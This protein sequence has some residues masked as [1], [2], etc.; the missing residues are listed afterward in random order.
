[1]MEQTNNIISGLYFIRNPFNCKGTEYWSRQCFESYCRPPNP[2][3]VKDLT[4]ASLDDN[5]ILE[6]LRWATLGYHHN[7]DTKVYT[8]LNFLI[9]GLLCYDFL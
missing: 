3:N 2:T 5:F 7:W 9:R 1:M 4:S 8:L 6:K